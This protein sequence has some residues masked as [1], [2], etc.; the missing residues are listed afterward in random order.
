MKSRTPIQIAICFAVC[1]TFL[2]NY[3][4]YQNQLT[5]LRMEI[6]ALAQTLKGIEEENLR[7]KYE[8]ERFENPWHLM[9][10]AK[11]SEFS[12]LRHPLL[13]EIVVIEHHAMPQQNPFT[14]TDDVQLTNQTPEKKD[15]KGRFWLF[16][17]MPIGA[18]SK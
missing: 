1:T 16:P 11:H 15:E 12:H 6:P 17:S 7:L 18:R 14:H 2:Y 8:I 10:L 3:L 9:D 13:E 4:S 5:Q